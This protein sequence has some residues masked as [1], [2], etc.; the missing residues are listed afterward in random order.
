M[1]IFGETVY[2]PTI[3]DKTREIEVQD[4]AR[5]NK[6]LYATSLTSMLVFTLFYVIIYCIFM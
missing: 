1:F 3:G 6:I 5:T 2:K 4:I